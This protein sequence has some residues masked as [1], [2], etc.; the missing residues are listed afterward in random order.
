MPLC[1]I[2]SS[3]RVARLHQTNY[4]ALHMPRYNKTI[5]ESHTMLASTTQTP[6]HWHAAAAASSL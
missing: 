2:C 5:N 4:K 6:A 3:G 1:K